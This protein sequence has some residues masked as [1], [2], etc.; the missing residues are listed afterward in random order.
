MII[1]LFT[2]SS[3]PTHVTRS[4]ASSLTTLWANQR[5]RLA[6]LGPLSK[7]TTEREASNFLFAVSRT[8]AALFNQEV[9]ADGAAFDLL[10][11]GRHLAVVMALESVVGGGLADFEGRALVGE[12]LELWL[13]RNTIRLA[14]HYTNLPRELDLPSLIHLM[15]VYLP[16]LKQVSILVASCKCLRL[17]Y[18]ELLGVVA[19]GDLRVLWIHLQNRQTALAVLITVLLFGGEGAIELV[20]TENLA[21]S[22]KS[23]VGFESDIKAQRVDA[24]STRLLLNLNSSE[25]HLVLRHVVSMIQLLAQSLLLGLGLMLLLSLI[26]LIDE[27]EYPIHV[28]YL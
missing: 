2:C 18:F 12:L 28:I 11:K 8:G 23:F 1:E 24:C 7:P 15:R 22:V 27:E 9:V 26:L 25:F 21:L 13:I 10:V 6:Q 17:A 5:L 20:P 16:E 14:V 19:F 3:C 4:R